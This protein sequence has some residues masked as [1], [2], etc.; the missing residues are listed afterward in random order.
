MTRRTAQSLNDCLH[1]GPVILCGLIMRFPLPSIA[2]FADM[3][4]AFLDIRI[5]VTRFLC[6]RDAT[7]LEDVDSNLETYRFCCVPIGLICSPFLL[8]EKIK[9][10]LRH[11]GSSLARTLA[12]NIYVD[13]V[14]IGADSRTEMYRISM[15]KRHVFFEKA[16][17]KLR[18][19]SSNS[20]ELLQ[21]LPKQIERA[22]KQS[23]FLEF[24]GTLQAT[25]FIF[26]DLRHY[27]PQMF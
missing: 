5:R 7:R 8:G 22:V 27:R 1:R 3:E 4:K 17:M 26:L 9:Y 15:N 11:E 25:S 6:F 23:V 14:L 16:S 13:N 24:P 10:H 21:L 19:W 12:D 18:Q 2:I 20:H